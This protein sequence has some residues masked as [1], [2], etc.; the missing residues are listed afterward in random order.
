MDTEREVLAYL[1]Q[2]FPTIS[3]AK[4]KEGIFIGSQM[5][6]PFKDQVY[7]IEL[8]RKKRLECI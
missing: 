2:N 7:K 8:Y 3:E 1:R 4:M 5:K 6:Q